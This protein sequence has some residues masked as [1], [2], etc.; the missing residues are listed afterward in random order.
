MGQSQ[1]FQGQDGFPNGT[2][3]TLDNSVE[4]Y[5]VDRELMD[6][7]LVKRSIACGAHYFAETPAISI[8]RIGQKLYECI[9]PNQSYSAPCVILADGVEPRLA[10]DLGWNTA[11]APEDLETCR[12]A[13]ITDESIS[14]DS[15]VFYI[16]DKITPA[17]YAWVFPRGKRMAN[18]GLG[19]L[20]SY[21]GPGKAKDLLEDFVKRNFPRAGSEDLHCGGFSGQMA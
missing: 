15:C 18:V 5:V 7:E 3:V 9:S 1:N 4:S 6:F 8:Q 20:G 14:P 17:G 13:K 19:V 10:R 11:L 2:T 21:S 16:G 12:F